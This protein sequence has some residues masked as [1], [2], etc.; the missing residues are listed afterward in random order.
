MTTITEA[1]ALSADHM[2]RHLTAA[3]LRSLKERANRRMIEINRKARA[4]R[5]ERWEW[6]RCLTVLTRT[7]GAL[8]L[9]AVAGRDRLDELDLPAEVVP[10]IRGSCE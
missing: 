10:V 8:S 4:S 9:T 7:A 5:S 1:A 6:D 2:A 3:E